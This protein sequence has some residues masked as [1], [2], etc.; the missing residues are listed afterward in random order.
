MI[1]VELTSENFVKASQCDEGSLVLVSSTEYEA[2]ANNN[3]SSVLHE[4]FAFDMEV[5]SV[6]VGASLL[7]FL[8][9]HGAGSVVRW[10]GRS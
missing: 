10:L 6:V 9:S 2:L 1:C 7:M 3:L 5:F 4:I 8:V